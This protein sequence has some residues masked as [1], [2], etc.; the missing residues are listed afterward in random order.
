MAGKNHAFRTAAKE[1][2]ATAT[3]WTLDNCSTMTIYQA[4]QELTRRGIFDE[5]FGADGEKKRIT[6]KACLQ[7]LV[8]E[9]VKEKE[10]ADRQ[11][12]A[13]VEATKLVGAQ[14]G[15]TLAEKLAREKAE[16]KQAA[17]ERS[18]QR[19][20]AK[21]YFEDRRKL[22]EENPVKQPPKKSF[23]EKD[24]V[25]VSSAESSVSPAASA[26][27]GGAGG[28]EGGEGDSAGDVAVAVTEKIANM[29]VGQGEEEEKGPGDEGT[30]SAAGSPAVDAGKA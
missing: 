26:S 9:L 15:E 10:E 19:Q 1:T 5:V 16:R 29:E 4:R 24:S 14:E 28:E 17:L 25:T 7:V 18:K 21:G 27:E 13:E 12:L 30:A 22:N 23:W 6:L 20:A 11:R 3:E 2:S 8:G